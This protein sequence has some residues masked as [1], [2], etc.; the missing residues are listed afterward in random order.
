VAASKQAKADVKKTITA[1][2]P[3]PYARLQSVAVA[4]TMPKPI[5]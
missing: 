5:A 1:P 3:S 4:S 2:I